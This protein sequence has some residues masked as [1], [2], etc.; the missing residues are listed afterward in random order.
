MT[1]HDAERTK[2]ELRSLSS[3]LA[4]SADKD[5]ATWSTERWVPEAVSLHGKIGPNRI[6]FF[7]VRIGQVAGAA[8]L[9]VFATAGTLGSG[10][11]WRWVTVA[12]SLTVALLTAFDQVYRPGLRWRGAY[13]YYHELVDAGW[14]YVET[15]ANQA[16]RANTPASVFV[17]TVENALKRQRIDYLR[18]IANLNT[19]ASGAEGTSAARGRK[20]QSRSDNARKQRGSQVRPASE[21]PSTT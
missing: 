4:S 10:N 20:T 3:Q 1:K 5:L 18:D 12:V 13:Q 8:S 2:R 15:M 16:R 14:V 19:S 7:V 17:T 11:T 9:P 6:W 21:K